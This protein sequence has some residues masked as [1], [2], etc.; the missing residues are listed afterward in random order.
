M[1]GAGGGREAEPESGLEGG[2]EKG[3]WDDQAQV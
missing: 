2:G 3:V 1:G